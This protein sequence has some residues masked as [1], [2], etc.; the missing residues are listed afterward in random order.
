M[1]AGAFT[2]STVDLDGP[3]HY[4]DFG[5]SGPPI[6][7]VHGLGGSHVNWVRV[8][9]ALSAFGHVLAPD[10]IGFGRTVPDRRSPAVLSNRV[11]VDRFIAEV[12]GGE[13]ILVGNSMGG[14]ISILQAARRPHRVNGLVLV[15]PALF[16]SPGHRPDPTFMLRGALLATPVL[17]GLLARTHEA[18]TTPEQRVREVLELCCVD[19]GKVPDD[20][21]A[22]HV[23]LTAERELMPW[24]LPAHVEA[25]RSI[26]GALIPPVFTRTLRNVVAPTLLVHGTEDRLVPVDAAR[27]V[28]ARRPD[29][30][31]T[32]LD[33]VGH[34]PMLDEAERLLDTI[35]PFIRDN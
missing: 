26:A 9:P 16:G 23:E 29:W 19:P 14:L 1:T 3:V 20:V 8:G 28:A 25:A 5:G 33:G 11:L 34:A 2:T 17:G 12:A 24:A 22:A 4:A 30:G 7:L 6:V 15:D 31:Y 27:H 10:L 32:E 21:V 13:A 18:R 35:V